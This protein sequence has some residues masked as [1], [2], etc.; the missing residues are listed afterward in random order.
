[1]R[2]KTPRERYKCMYSYVRRVVFYTRNRLELHDLVPFDDISLLITCNDHFH[3]GRK[4]PMR[5]NNHYGKTHA[6]RKAL[7]KALG[8]LG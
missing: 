4:Q 3:T 8:E 1:M 6:F 2:K 7:K 5:Q